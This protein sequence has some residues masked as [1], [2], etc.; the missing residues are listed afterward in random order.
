MLTWKVGHETHLEVRRN[1]RADEMSFCAT[2]DQTVAQLRIRG[3]AY[4]EEKALEA[5]ELAK[6]EALSGT[7][8]YEDDDDPFRFREQSELDKTKSFKSRYAWVRRDQQHVRSAER[9]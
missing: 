6:Q 1:Q 7:I 8:T 5:E 9:C 2:P 3:E 4:Q